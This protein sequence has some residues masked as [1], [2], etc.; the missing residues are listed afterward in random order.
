MHCCRKRACNHRTLAI[1]GDL[2]AL[3]A[4]Q[5][6]VSAMLHAAGENKVSWRQLVKPVLTHV[7]GVWSFLSHAI[8][9]DPSH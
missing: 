5:P 7:G 2:V 4:M 6:K 3:Q 1:V 9:S 8:N